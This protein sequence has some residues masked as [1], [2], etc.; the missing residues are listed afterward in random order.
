MELAPEVSVDEGDLAELCKRHSIRRLALFGSAIHG[1][2]HVDSDIDLLVEF[3]P[4]HVPGLIG[5]AAIELELRDLI[6]RDVDLRT[7][8]DL[9]QYFR[10]QVTDEARELYDAA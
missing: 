6:G 7:P 1:D 10:D 4:G 2:F 3:V 9:S 8:N 5:L